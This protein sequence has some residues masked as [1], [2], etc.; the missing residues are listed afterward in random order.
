MLQYIYCFDGFHYFT[1]LGRQ[2]LQVYISTKPRD[3]YKQLM[4]V[5]ILD[6]TLYIQANIPI[7]NQAIS[8]IN[9][10]LQQVHL[11]P[12]TS[13]SGVTVGAGISSKSRDR[14]HNYSYHKNITFINIVIEHAQLSMLSHK[15]TSHVLSLQRMGGDLSLDFEGTK[16]HFSR[17][18]KRFSRIISERPFQK[19]IHFTG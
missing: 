2:L 14:V 9:A 13:G 4:F 5:A 3:M 11:Q 6:I 10:V 8:N 7:Y 12:G 15:P 17:F 1:I 18:P 19:K 16:G